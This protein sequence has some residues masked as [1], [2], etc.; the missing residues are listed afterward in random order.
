MGFSGN[1]QSKEGPVQLADFPKLK[2]VRG[3][4]NHRQ[5]PG[6]QDSDICVYTY[7]ACC[8]MAV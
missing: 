2:G 7:P 5:L 4:L 8:G 6:A 3:F 1:G